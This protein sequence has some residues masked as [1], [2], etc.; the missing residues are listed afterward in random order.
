[1]ELGSPWYDYQQLT[2]LHE[3]GG[4]NIHRDCPVKSYGRDEPGA[5]ILSLGDESDVDI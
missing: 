3:R 2:D 1:M 4:C 5:I